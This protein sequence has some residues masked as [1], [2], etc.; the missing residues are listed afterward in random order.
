MPDAVS[1][2]VWSS[3]N[4]TPLEIATV[5]VALSPSLIAWGTAETVKFAGDTVPV[6]VPVLSA[7][8]LP[9]TSDLLAMTRTVYSVRASRFGIV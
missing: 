7:E 9:S 6:G 3:A 8:G 1:E 4:V 5:T 2:S